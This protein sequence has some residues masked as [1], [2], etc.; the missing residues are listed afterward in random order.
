[1]GQENKVVKTGQKV[2]IHCLTISYLAFNISKI[3]PRGDAAADA[4]SSLP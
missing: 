2:Q 1:M 3:S 4:D